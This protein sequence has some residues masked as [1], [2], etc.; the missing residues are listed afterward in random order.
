MA[1]VVYIAVVVAFLGLCV[2]YVR[3]IDRMISA[4]DD[5][6]AGGDA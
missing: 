5:E 6:G 2:A 4:A 1:D 3:G